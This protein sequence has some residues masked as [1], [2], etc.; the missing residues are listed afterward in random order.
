M[1]SIW[2]IT[3]SLKRNHFQMEPESAA[4]YSKRSYWDARYA[5]E[6]SYDWFGSVYNSCLQY[7]FQSIESV[8]HASLKLKSLPD[9]EKEVLNG[10]PR[11]IKVLHL[12]CGNSALCGDIVR[13]WRNK[14]FPDKCGA[15]LVESPKF[16]NENLTKYFTD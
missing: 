4:D 6:D 3:V 7:V 11:E 8:F 1:T 5:L 14:Y 16:L 12:G 10:S 13:L 15:H 9:W 2:E